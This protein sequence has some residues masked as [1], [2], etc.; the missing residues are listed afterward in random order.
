ME[1]ARTESTR[2]T[3]GLLL[4]VVLPVLV[5]FGAEAAGYGRFVRLAVL[6][7]SAAAVGIGVFTHPRAAAYF[8]AFY[9]FAGLGT[10]LP[11]ALA[12]L[13]VLTAVAATFVAILRGEQ[14]ELRD[15]VFLWALGFFVLLCCH[16]ML[17]AHYMELSLHSMFAF[18][19]VFALVFVLVQYTR[20]PAQLRHLGLAVF[21]GAVAT[22]IA[23][24]IAFRLGIDID[25]G[26]RASVNFLP[27]F[28]GLHADPNYG[29][30]HMCAAIPLGVFF[31]RSEKRRWM[32]FFYI[33]C[34]SIVFLGA[35]LTLSRGGFLALGVVVLGII[36]REARS[37]RAH[38]GVLALLIAIPLLSPPEYWQRLV[39]LSNLM[40]RASK[41]WALLTRMRALETAW[42][43]AK[44][45]W[46]TGIG[47]GNFIM[48]GDVGVWVRIVVHNA[49]M[50]IFVGAGIFGLVAYLTMLLAG[51]RQMVRG[52]RMRLDWPRW[53]PDLC[54]YFA[55]SL[56]AAGASALF[57]S[58][59]YR[60]LFWVPTAAGL[61]IGNIIRDR[62][63]P[64][65]R[66]A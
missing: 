56:V 28:S 38:I 63:R 36:V 6:G 20:T 48:R 52:A 12:Q 47:I 13:V 40:E 60:Y 41:D 29:S 42:M 44:E 35:F 19:K 8:L 59:Q 51:F 37:R 54:Y 24:L 57:L 53:M 9:A 65:P 15:P 31:V 17:Y 66:P 10:I 14:V 62:R 33:V 32:R 49:Y 11:S 58:I 1:A 50:E 5:F 64:A 55:L 7:A 39:T 4:L 25:P 34:L 23:G 43:L 3:A 27:R 46:A 30:A 26:L 22:V 21:F 2:A 61:A 16:S 18:A 45:N